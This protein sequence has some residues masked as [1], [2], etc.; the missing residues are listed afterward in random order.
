MTP[1]PLPPVLREAAARKV[2]ALP[3]AR[4]GAARALGR[5]AAYGR[6]RASAAGRAAAARRR[7]PRRGGRRSSPASL[8]RGGG[9]LRPDEVEAL[10]GAYGI[11]LVEQRRVGSAAAAAKAAAEL[12]GP[13][14]LKGIAPGVVHKAQAGAVR[15]G[16][17]RPDRGPARGQDV[18]QALEAAGTPVEDFLVQRM[19]G[20]ASRCSSACWPTSAS[21]RSWPAA[22]AAA[23]PRCSSDVPVRLAPLAHEDAHDMIR[24]LRSLRC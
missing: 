14:A 12:G 15:L 4:G 21:G 7:R 1:G 24:A 3:G 13:V 18:A 2:A 10:L 9:W 19:A 11:P 17:S 23:R 8:A 22:P 5:A 6:W 16:L 20:R